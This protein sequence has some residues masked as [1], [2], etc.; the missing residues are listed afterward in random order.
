MLDI[1]GINIK[2][3]SEDIAKPQVFFSKRSCMYMEHWW[4]C[5][6]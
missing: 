3:R 5:F 6:L 1:A 2:L 4:G